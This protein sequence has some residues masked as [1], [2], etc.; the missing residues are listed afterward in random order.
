MVQ[1]RCGDVGRPDFSDSD[2]ARLR[3]LAEE[4]EHV[5]WLRARRKERME[6]M[7]GWFTWITAAW[8]LKDLLWE[9]VVGLI[10]DHWR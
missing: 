2:R 5:A 4:R 6:A 1:S 9:T 10:R 3:E 7:R 8:A